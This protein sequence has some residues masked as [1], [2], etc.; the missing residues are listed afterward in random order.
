[1]RFVK[2]LLFALLAIP[3]AY[4]ETVDD[5][6]TRC[7][8]YL[9]SR[10][11]AGVIGA[12]TSA[13]DSG[14]LTNAAL[15]DAFTFRGWAYRVNNQPE[16]ALK[17][18]S[19]AI[20]LDSFNAWSFVQRGLTFVQITE[21]DRALQDYDQALRIQPDYAWAFA[22]RGDV[23]Y[24]LSNYERAIADYNQAIVNESGS[25]N[26][27]LGLTALIEVRFDRGRALARSGD[28][29]QAIRDFDA[30]IAHDPRWN[31]ALR[32][33]GL[34]YTYMRQHERAFRDF[35]QA[36][37]GGPDIVA[38]ALRGAIYSERGELDLALE[39]YNTALRLAPGDPWLLDGRGRVHA[40]KGEYFEAIADFNESARKE[41]R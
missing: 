30:C 8:A 9:P 1:M 40:K 13:I 36:V 14:R 17:D 23:Y 15:S 16:R 22:V 2:G 29:D 11:G 33:R 41:V 6:W 19:R 18:L 7:Q 26:E 5:Q 35:D 37:K 28:F 27:A 3:S 34:A 24:S 4:A 10:D 31:E 12:C 25:G 21:Y 38:L 39:D 32:E 20:Q